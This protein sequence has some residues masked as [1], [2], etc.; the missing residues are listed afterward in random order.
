MLIR[1]VAKVLAEWFDQA[2]AARE[3]RVHGQGVRSTD[4]ARRRARK[5]CKIICANASCSGPLLLTV[6]FKLHRGFHGG[7]PPLDF[8]SG[9]W[10]GGGRGF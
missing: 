3:G 10:A 2:R 9:G 7:L 6:I 4:G 1:F 8:R 5:L